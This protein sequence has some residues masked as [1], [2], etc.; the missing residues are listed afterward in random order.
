[1]RNIAIL[2]LLSITQR[3][4]IKVSNSQHI[5]NTGGGKKEKYILTRRHFGGAIE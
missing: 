5:Q 3:E 4:K 1:M 2:L